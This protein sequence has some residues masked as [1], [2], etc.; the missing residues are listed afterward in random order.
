MPSNMKEKWNRTDLVRER[1]RGLKQGK[2]LD[3]PV[4]SIY[5]ITEEVLVDGVDV[6]LLAIKEGKGVILYY[7]DK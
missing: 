1:V 5:K 4:G 6:R 2:K 3:I 7:K